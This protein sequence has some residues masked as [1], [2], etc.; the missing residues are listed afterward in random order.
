MVKSIPY[1]LVILSGLFNVLANVQMKA[2]HNLQSEDPSLMVSSL[3]AGSAV[4]FY[5]LAFVCYFAC[6]KFLD[7][8]YAYIL[9]TALTM[10]TLITLSSMT[11]GAVDRYKVIGA[12]VIIAGIYLVTKSDA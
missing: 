12:C 6:L 4:L 11:D 3:Y 9:V 2:T 8:S 1:I 7:T 10:L 5:G